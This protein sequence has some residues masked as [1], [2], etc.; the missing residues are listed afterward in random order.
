MRGR[1]II[2]IS[3]MAM[4]L[5]ALTMV[6]S[7]KSQDGTVL[8][9]SPTMLPADGSIGHVGDSYALSVN[10]AYAMD[11]WAVQFRIAFAPYTSVLGISNINEGAFLSEGYWPTFFT[12]TIDAF[13]GYADVAI[14]RLPNPDFPG[15]KYG[16]N[17]DGELATF[18]LNVVEAGESPITLENVILLDTTGTQMPATTTGSFFHGVIATLLRVTGLGATEDIYHVKR[19]HVGQTV[20]WSTLVT[21]YYDVPLYVRAR[22]DVIREEDGRYIKLY[23]G[24]TYLDGAFGEDPAESL[25]LYV[26]GYTGSY[27]TWGWNYSGVAPYLNAVG[28]G[29]YVWCDGSSMGMIPENGNWYPTTGR[30][31]FQDYTIPE[32]RI[33]NS[34]VLEAYTRYSAPDED[35]DLDTYMRDAAE[36][37]PSTWIGS[38]WGNALYGWVTP[39]WVDNA[40]LT[41]FIPSLATQTGINAARVRFVMY[42]TADDLPHQTAWIDAMRLQVNTYP[43]RFG[44]QGDVSYKRVNPGSEVDLPHASFYKAL[45]SHV[46]TYHV[47]VTI[48]YTINFL[49][50]N[51]MGTEQRAFTFTVRP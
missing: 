24:Q 16:A 42:W 11:L 4:L 41:D 9:I 20:H 50:W 46:G 14:V 26:N 15:E 31:D 27:H 8:S 13:H 6:P 30:Y 22:Y 35:M 18:N 45:E 25:Y 7:G 44:V 1:N 19:I 49:R 38:L 5:S 2:W 12:F 10:I 17:G 21:N 23:T 36:A 34:V 32:G 3:I 37:P 48:E 43:A 39:R 29:N 28:D 51:D 33:I 40:P 47:T